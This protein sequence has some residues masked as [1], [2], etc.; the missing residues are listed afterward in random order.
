MNQRGELG[1][2]FVQSVEP[3]CFSNPRRQIETF[4]FVLERGPGALP[5]ALNCL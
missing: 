3:P 1:E 5:M 4:D 2:F